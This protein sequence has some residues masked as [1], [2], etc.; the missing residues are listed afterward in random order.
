M[1]A[2]WN[3]TTVKLTKHGRKMFTWS[4]RRSASGRHYWVL[5]P[6]ISATRRRTY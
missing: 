4:L 3:P 6:R 1:I 5:V 2:T